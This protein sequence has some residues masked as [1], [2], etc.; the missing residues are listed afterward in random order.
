[1][2]ARRKG[3][4]FLRLP[5]TAL[6]FCLSITAAPPGHEQMVADLL[7]QL[8]SAEPSQRPQLIRELQDLGPGAQAAPALATALADPSDA[9][10]SAALSAV[11][12]IGPDAAA[13]VPALIELWRGGFH[14]TTIAGIFG[15]IGPA[16]RAAVPELIAGLDDP[17]IDT[18]YWSAT[19]LGRLG[20]AAHAAVPKLIEMLGDSNARVRAGAV[21]GLTRLGPA[22]KP[23]VPAFTRMLASDE[24]I[25]R[26]LAAKALRQL[27]GNA[28][29]AAPAIIGR[30]QVEDSAAVRRELIYAIRAMPAHSAP[31]IPLLRASLSSENKDVRVAACRTLNTLEGANRKCESGLAPHSGPF[32]V[33]DGRPKPLSPED[34]ARLPA[35]IESLGT[36]E[37]HNR[38]VAAQ[39]LHALRPIE[40]AAIAA[41]T[42][43]LEDE[44]EA[45][46]DEAAAALRDIGPAAVPGLRRALRHAR[47]PVQLEACTGLQS[48]RAITQETLP[49]L[50]EAAEAGE[51]TGLTRC[52]V[53]AISS[54]G[55][56]AQPAAPFLI[57]TL[58]DEDPTIRTAAAR[59]LA[60]IGPPAAN[61]RNALR[62]L[63]RDS[64]GEARMAAISAIARVAPRTPET[65]NLIT[66]ALSDEDPRVRR[67]AA[68]ILGAFGCAAKG[69]A[70]LLNQRLRDPAPEVRDAAAR[71]LGMVACEADAATVAQ[72]I[73]ALRSPR[74]RV[75]EQAA[76]SLGKM[77]ERAR[78]ALN[79]LTIALED[80]SYIVRMT[81]ARALG[82]LD[83]PAAVPPLTRALEDNAPMVRYSAAYALATIGPDAA[84]AVAALQQLRNDE[85]WWARRMAATAIEQI[86][87]PAARISR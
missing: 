52:V 68:N 29:A 13:A 9:V 19:A 84:P 49:P 23:A 21:S 85:D 86:T 1:M 27:R 81:A 76:R 72:L 45:V 20:N 25:S 47:V 44:S 32:N 57:R 28:A 5:F 74:M 64:D 15:M 24:A 2:R 17:D 39:Q 56:R 66:T 51:N 55:P 79:I 8:E 41:L 87:D 69:S 59:A 53:N 61:A 83:D 77:G 36:A 11:H 58:A 67:R 31:A 78:P 3:L 16:A 63:A 22:A 30:L 18:R 80:P 65:M 60:R 70:N 6:L 62:Q 82:F 26:L 50:V 46:Q 33:V 7:R 54:L 75:R 34:E 14:R 48:A 43:A 38:L 4:F 40:E 71:A 10:K 42:A 37:E 73:D 12:W 35:L